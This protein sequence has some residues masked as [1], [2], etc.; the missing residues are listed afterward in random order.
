MRLLK[1]IIFACIL[2]PFAGYAQEWSDVPADKREL[3]AKNMLLYQRANGGWPKH[4]KAKAINY[5]VS[6][7]E[8]DLTIMKSNH[9]SGIDATID[10]SAT[11]KE[12][13]FLAAEFTQ[14]NKKEYLQAVEKGIAYLL[15]AQY[16]NG[17]W[18][19]YYPDNRF[20]RHL[21]TYNDNAMI[22]VL[23]VLEDV[24]YGKMHM[25]LVDKSLVLKAAKAIEK[26]ID[27]ILKTQIKVNGK[28]TVWSAQHD[29]KTFAPA[30][31][32][33]FEP[34]SLSGSE[35]VGIVQFLMK[36][37]KP[38]AEIKAAVV[39]A[40]EWFEKVKI[41]GYKFVSGR[42]ALKGKQ[43]NLVEDTNSVVWARFYEIE[44]NE[45]FFTGRDGVKKK[46]MYEI[47]A[48]RRNG[49]A[50]Y[51]T[52]PQKVL[53]AYPKWAGANLISSVSGK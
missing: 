45:P 10:N 19:Q 32:R 28:L 44:T 36:Q 13:R 6:L 4:F 26:G 21:I 40:V 47:D 2:F 29:E 39:S 31:A 38:S 15:A 18:P 46:S 14:T 35:S 33:I 5:S 51:G 22:N 9:A 49:Y 37:E 52:W 8:A 48:E 12:I 23:N 25:G 41:S 7:S 50:W 27:C 53:K 1:T 16:D 17:G 24:K 20:Y 34:A 3:I 11:I 30:S 42:D 43:Q